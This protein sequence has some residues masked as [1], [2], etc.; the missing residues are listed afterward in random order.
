MSR[1]LLSILGILVSVSCLWIATT[2]Y[3]AGFDWN[4]DYV[5]TLLRGPA[6]AARNFADAGVLI[7]CVSIA[8]VFD[9]LARA[10]E[11]SKDAKLIRI[12]GIG[13]MVYS[14]FTITPMHDLMVT[15]SIVFF[16]IGVVPLTRALYVGRES[17][18]FTA[19]CGCLAVFVASATIYYSG[20]YTSVLPWA[21][22]A[23]YSL[24]AGWLVAL[25]Y[26]FSRG[27]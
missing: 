26:R 9:R 15:I 18:F 21:Q 12:G 22:R 27:P 7:F 25:D 8:W 1:R 3:P 11:F 2:R 20:I 24:F 16:L 23:S 4:R 6:G 13:S 14:A 19:G 17:L 10:D 5:S